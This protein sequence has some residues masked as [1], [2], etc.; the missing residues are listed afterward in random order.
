M[1]NKEQLRLSAVKKFLSLE[2]NT[3]KSLDNIAMLASHICQT[4]VSFV[5]LMDKDIQWMRGCYGYEVDKMPVETSFCK[6]TICQED[7][8]EVDDTFQN[9]QFSHYPVL[10]M[11]PAA[12]F[13]AGIPLKSF[14][15]Y[16]IGTLCVMHIQPHKLNDDQKFALRNLSKQV[17]VILEMEW[18]KKL[19]NQTIK[20]L[21]GKNEAI[22]LKNKQLKHVAQIQ[23]HDVRGP[24]SAALSVMYL[25]KLEGYKPQNKQLQLLEEAL[26]QLDAKVCE[27]VKLSAVA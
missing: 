20:E 1:K 26:N 21:E 18:S 19:L 7:V 8:F 4:P 22:M 24:L 25:I 16:N 11:N 5:T 17:A 6:H 14:D 15:N 10:H 12:R 2:L 23:S 27:A 13:Y 3:E 9:P